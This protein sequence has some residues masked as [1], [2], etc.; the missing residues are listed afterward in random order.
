MELSAGG[1]WD[2]GACSREG[3][4]DPTRGPTGLSVTANTPVKKGGDA[5]HGKLTVK[6]MAVYIADWARE[7]NLPHAKITTGYYELWYP[8]D[9]DFDVHTAPASIAEYIQCGETNAVV[10]R[11]RPYDKAFLRSC[12]F[13][14]ATLFPQGTLRHLLQLESA[15]LNSNK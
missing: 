6:K 3:R 1:P 13:M 8:W 14:A 11:S 2:A 5:A 9:S 7:R 12:F 4:S 15:V 10:S